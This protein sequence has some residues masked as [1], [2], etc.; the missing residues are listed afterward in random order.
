MKQPYQFY[1]VVLPGLEPMVE[2]ELN[3]LSAHD[4]R[5]EAG[6]VRFSGTLDTL[7][8]VSLRARCLTR[9]QVRVGKCHAMSLPEL[10]H[11]I[12]TMLWERFIPKGADVEVKASSEHSKLMHSDLIAEHVFAGIHDALGKRLDKSGNSKQCVYVHIN[13]N[14]CEVRMDASGERLDK[15]GYRLDAAKAP[16]R[17]TM[18]AGILQ[19][20]NYQANESLYIP[21][22]GSGTLAIEAAMIGRK[23]APNITHAFP[24]RGWDIF[25]EK[26]WK[27][28]LEKA[29]AMEKEALPEK[30]HASDHH[31]AAI[32][33]TKANAKR[34]NVLQDIRITQQDVFHIKAQGDTGLMVCNPPYG[35][36]IQTDSIKFYRELGHTLKDKFSAWRI[37]VMCPDWKHEKALA[38]PVKRRLRIL[39]GGIWLDVLDVSA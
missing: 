36:R 7:Y 33:A 27:R 24:F 8:R 26:A 32:K 3:G 30:V 21:M 16:M 23:I 22:C 4:I 10:Q 9:V 15:R 2:Q 39:H 31:V 14:R 13:N 18:A 11:H 5:S 29:V 34:A 12:S 25:K 1:A 17:E 37:A 35:L 28:V 20:M 19:W 6:A 38:M